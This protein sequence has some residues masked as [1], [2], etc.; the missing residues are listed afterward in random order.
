MA[1]T[2]KQ[3]LKLALQRTETRVRQIREFI[4]F[5]DP[6]LS[7]TRSDR[8]LDWLNQVNSKLHTAAHEI[9]L[10]EEERDYGG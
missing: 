6:I 2:A 10:W 7:D 9:M 4:D 3:E 5:D 1:L 8:L